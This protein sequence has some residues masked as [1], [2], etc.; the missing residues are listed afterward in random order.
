MAPKP[1]LLKDGFYRVGMKNKLIRAVQMRC[2]A[3][4][5][6]PIILNAAQISG[7]TPPC[8]P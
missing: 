6:V 5:G 4:L 3:K 1:D 8:P 7:G 2:T